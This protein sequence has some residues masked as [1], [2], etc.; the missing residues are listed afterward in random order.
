M[1]KHLKKITVIAAALIILAMA[2]LWYSGSRDRLIA[3][4]VAVVLGNQVYANGQPSPRLAARLDKGLEL[5][6][7]GTVKTIIVSG[8]I[9]KSQVD[10]AVAMAAYLTA[11]GLPRAAIVIDSNGVNSWKTAEFTAAWLQKNKLGGAIVVTQP[12]HV[13]RSVMALKAAGCPQ[14]GWASPDYWEWRDIYSTLREIPA[15][16]VYWWKY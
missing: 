8:G 11:K 6:R 4:Q 10:E 15:I 5:Y 3:A 9:G 16:L 7:N 2:A 14:V 13:R 12:F 1:K